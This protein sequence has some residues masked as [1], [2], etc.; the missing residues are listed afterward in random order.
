MAAIVA[1]F[2]AMLP[3]GFRQ[4][5]VFEQLLFAGGALYAGTLHEDQQSGLV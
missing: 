4:F 2:S 1:F 3:S 5:G